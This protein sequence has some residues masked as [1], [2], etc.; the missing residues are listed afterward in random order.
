[1]TAHVAVQEGDE[2]IC[3]TCGAKASVAKGWTASSGDKVSDDCERAQKEIQEINRR[4][5]H[6]ADAQQRNMRQDMA[7]KKIMDAL[8]QSSGVPPIGAILL[9]QWPEDVLQSTRFAEGVPP[10][11]MMS[12]VDNLMGLLRTLGDQLKKAINTRRVTGAPGTQ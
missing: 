6:L 1:M 8:H 3:A 4:A 2:T 9:V 11:K 5:T 7:L 12:V 10:Q